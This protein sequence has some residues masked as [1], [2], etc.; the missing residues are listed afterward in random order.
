MVQVDRL[1]RA[2]ASLRRQQPYRTGDPPLQAWGE[3]L[4]FRWKPERWQDQRGG[5]HDT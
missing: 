3:E 1:R 2:R 5:L 4:A